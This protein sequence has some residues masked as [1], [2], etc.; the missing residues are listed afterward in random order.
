ML[1]ELLQR[2]LSATWIACER[3]GIATGFEE[4][5]ILYDMV[6]AV[7]KN[8]KVS[9]AAKKYRESFVLNAD[10]FHT[11]CSLYDG[12]N[13]KLDA[14]A[15]VGAY[16]LKTSR[17]S[18]IYQIFILSLLAVG[19]DDLVSDHFSDIALVLGS[20]SD[21]VSGEVVTGLKKIASSIKKYEEKDKEFQK[22]DP[23]EAISWLQV[24]CPT[25]AR[26]LDT[27]LKTHGHRCIQ[28]MDFLSEPWSLKPENLITTLQM[29]MNTTDMNSPNKALTTEETI[30]LLK[31]PKSSF[32]KWILKKVVPYSREAVVRRELTKAIFVDIVHTFRLAYRRLAKLMVLEGYLP[33]EGLIFFLTN[34]EI[35]QILNDHNTTL[36][37]KAFRRKRIFPRLYELKYPEMNTGMPIPEKEDLDAVIDEGSV[38]VQGTPVCGGSIVSRVCVITDVADAKEIQQG[39]ILITRS[40]DIAWSPYFPLLSGVVTEMGGLISH[41][42]VV[43]REYG[44]PCI[45]SAK[46]AT[47][48][49]RTGDT[50]LLAADAGV[51][52]LVKK[53]D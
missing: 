43:A 16:H 12:I 47:Q 40:T 52:Q 14:L 53:H 1:R 27:L 45:I 28:E 32:V 36:V 2:V 19:Y 29:M 24:N 35:G 4:V 46:K 5:L 3:N 44:L 49:F 25:A 37:Q 48:L 34:K 30:A 21:I 18:I 13:Q 10:D 15:I 31:T 26:E 20:C 11:A 41:G 42:A 51:L 33:E 17:V 7:M 38:K 6:K 9:E 50:V 23:R 22:I 8:I 39:D